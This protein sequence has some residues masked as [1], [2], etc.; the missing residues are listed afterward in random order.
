MTTA[1]AEPREHTEI[2]RIEAWR[3]E[4]LEAA[5]Y[6]GKSAAELAT[7]H[8]VDLHQAVDL[9]RNGCSQELALAILL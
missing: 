9:R 2:E 7:R 8:Y 5:G 1:Q 6:D 4:R 3:A